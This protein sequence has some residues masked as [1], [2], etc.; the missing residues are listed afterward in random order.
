[1]KNLSLCWLKPLLPLLLGAGM[2]GGWSAPALAGDKIEFFSTSS[3]DLE[4]PKAERPDEEQAD[5]L[6]GFSFKKPDS[7]SGMTQYRMTT[8]P[9]ETPAR[10]NND[11]NFWGENPR[12]DNGGLGWEMDRQDQNNP[13][14]DFSWGGRATNSTSKPATNDLNSLGAWRT[15]DSPNDLARDIRRTDPRYGQ[16]DPRLESLNPSA[17]R[18]SQNDFGPGS[19][20]LRPW[21]ARKE[22]AYGSSA[23]K[24][25]A[26][27]LKSQN[28]S[29][30]G[31]NLGLFNTTSR[32]SGLRTLSAFGA[33]PA[34]PSVSPFLP[35]LSAAEPD[36]NG[37]KEPPARASS[38]GSGRFSGNQDPGSAGDLPALRA[39]D[40]M[41]GPA[42]PASQPAPPRKP[43]APGSQP[44]AQQ[45]QSGNAMNLPRPKMPSPFGN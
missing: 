34:M 24:P 22:D 45:Q 16:L 4:M 8:A 1:V 9:T 7:I 29:L 18:D 40:D 33:A 37:Y 12:K 35:P 15:S 25:D 14:E 41:P 39:W 17:M 10:R 30:F 42:S 32:F 20:E 38:L 2:P 36:Y 28:R 3:E 26:D 31:D 23:R 13:F 6:S 27:L 11:R 44:G 5:I 21:A 43:A 19:A